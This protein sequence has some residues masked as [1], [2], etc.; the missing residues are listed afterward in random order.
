MNSTQYTLLIRSDKAESK[1]GRI[2]EKVDA[3]E[4]HL[5]IVPLEREVESSGITTEQV[6]ALK[7]KN[8]VLLKEN[9]KLKRDIN[10]LEKNV[11][12]L[13]DEIGVH[14]NTIKQ[15]ML[16]DKYKKDQTQAVKDK[17]DRLSELLSGQERDFI[18]CRDNFTLPR[19]KLERYL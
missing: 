13:K 1:N 3:L 15:T 6:I 12:D 14:W 17:L 16:E 18:E 4:P 7:R 5:N 2:D 8:A 11:E 19:A 10:K 9:L